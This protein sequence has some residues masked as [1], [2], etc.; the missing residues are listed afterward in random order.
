MLPGNQTIYHKLNSLSNYR[1]RQRERLSATR[2][3]G[4]RDVQEI[5]QRVVFLLRILG[6]QDSHL[7]T[8]SR[9]EVQHLEDVTAHGRTIAEKAP[10]KRQCPI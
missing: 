8:P 9:T 3:Q 7:V 10:S 4:R 6:I 2:R 5:A 1:Q